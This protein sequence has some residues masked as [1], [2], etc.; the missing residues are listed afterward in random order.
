MEAGVSHNRGG[1]AG[2]INSQLRSMS[3]CLGGTPGGKS[4]DKE[5][6]ASGA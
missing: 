1:L 6:R 4:R 5:R 2:P 3:G